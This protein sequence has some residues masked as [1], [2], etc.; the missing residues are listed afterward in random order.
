MAAGSGPITHSQTS[1]M[2]ATFA[3]GV[4]VTVSFW[5]YTSTESC[6]DHL[7]VLV[8]GAQ[9]GQWQGTT[10][11]TEA[12]VSLPSGSHTVQWRYV[13]DGSVSTGDDRVYIDDVTV[14]PGTGGAEGFEAAGLPPGFTT[15]GSASWFSSAAQAHTGARSAESGDIADSQRTSLF[16]TASYAAAGPLSFW[17]RVSTESSFD[18]LEFYLDGTRQDRWA[19][20]LTTWT[21]ASYAVTAGSHSLE[22]RYIKD[23]SVSSGA[24]TVW[25]DDVVATDATPPSGSLCGP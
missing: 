19:G 6:C 9:Q 16:Y 22:W 4:P 2:T 10:S 7:Q 13:K 25:I 1:T 15:S 18:Y 5:L 23:G 11:W 14:R 24:D 12:S 20:S 21:Q 8:D 3:F 17:R